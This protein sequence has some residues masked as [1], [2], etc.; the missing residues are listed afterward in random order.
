MVTEMALTVGSMFIGVGEAK[1][2]GTAAEIEAALET[3][4]TTGKVGKGGRLGNAATRSQIEEI[5]AE[6]KAREYEIT[7]GGLLGPEEY[8]PPIGG[9]R[10]GG[11]YIDITAKHPN[12]P[13][14]RINT[15]DV[16]KRTGL[17]TN[18]ELINAERIRK[19]IVPGEHLLL[20]P[21][22]VK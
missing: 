5:V 22:R 17:P 9:G 8:L 1:A 19:Q 20:I 16:Y 14:L 12:Y 15:V 18:R 2:V 3:I 4:G 21:K 10:K 6:L 13:T 11:S 7:G